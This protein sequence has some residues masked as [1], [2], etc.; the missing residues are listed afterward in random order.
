VERVASIF[1]LEEEDMKEA[2]LKWATDRGLRMEAIYSSETLVDF[3]LTTLYYIRKD[4][5]L[6]N[7]R[8]ENLKSETV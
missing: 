1:L 4:R 7:Y 6:C 2:N 3:Q 8:W 5:A